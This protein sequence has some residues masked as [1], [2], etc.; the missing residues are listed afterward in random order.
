MKKTQTPTQKIKN[1]ISKV[2][3]KPNPLF[4]NLPPCP[5]ARKAILQNKVQFVELPSTAD[6][7]TVYQFVLS[8]I[9]I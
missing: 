8:L 9:H 4:G 6:W 1:W 5:F 3:T 7:R 2:I